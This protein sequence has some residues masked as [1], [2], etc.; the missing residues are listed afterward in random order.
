MEEETRNK[1]EENCRSISC[2]A[3]WLKWTLNCE[4]Y[5]YFSFTSNQ[6]SI[7]SESCLPQQHK[8]RIAGY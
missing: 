7:T 6:G 8:Q 1:S 3:W 2:F 4:P 5:Q